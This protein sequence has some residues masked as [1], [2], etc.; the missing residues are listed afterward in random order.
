MQFST[1]TS[2][3]LAAALATAASAHVVMENPP[4]AKFL[5]YGPTNPIEPTGSDWPCKIPAGQKLDMSDASPKTEMVIG[6]TQ[7]FSVKGTAVHGGGS[8]QFALTKGWDPKKDSPWSV[9]HSIEGG[10]PARNQKGNLDGANKDEYEFKIPAGIAP[11]QYTFSWT[12]NNRIGG[13]PEF[14]QNCGLIVVKGAKTKRMD[15]SARRDLVAMSKRA[16]DFPEL[17]MANIGELSGGCTT[18]EALK[19]QISIAYPD[20]GESV[21]HANGN[22]QLFKQPC[23][24]NPRARKGGDRGSGASP[25]PAP[26]PAPVPE[27]AVPT[28]PQGPKPEPSTSPAAKP[29]SAAPIPTHVVPAP[30]PSSIA[31]PAPSGAAPI[32]DG[33]APGAGG[34]MDPSSPCTHGQLG[35]SNSGLEAYSCTGGKWVKIFDVP[36]SDPPRKCKPGV[37]NGENLILV[38]A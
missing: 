32:P 35:C 22:E 14:Y 1:S 21:D 4:P 20:P 29:T 38:D 18:G 3:I 25:A 31:H 26:A 6:E 8:C 7:K 12:W 33:N 17:F 19:Q 37:G 13:Q 15:M 24:G 30:E 2:S 34:A 11:G 28:V 36:H 27:P 10:C 5:A 16:P 23:D 9:I